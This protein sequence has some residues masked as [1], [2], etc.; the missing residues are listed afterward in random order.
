MET[1]EAVHREG[2]ERLH[3][4]LTN[5]NWLVLR[6][7]REIFREW[8]AGIERKGLRVLDL[9]GRIQPYRP[10]LS[11]RIERYLAVDLRQSPLVDIVAR[12]EEIPIG[13]D[14]VDL[15]ICA[16]VLEYIQD[17]AA[18]LAEIHRVLKPG[19]ML[20]LSAPAVYPCDSEHDLW[21]FLP[22]SLRWLLRGFHDVEIVA[23]GSS[24]AGLFRSANV[25]LV[26]F[27][28]PA[29]VRELLHFALVPVLNV[30]AAT[31]E[32]LVASSNDQFAANFSVSAR[33]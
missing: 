30:T 3:P 4:S 17:P 7:R 24:I 21:R 19:G 6:R 25:C 11:G 32:S 5:P 26:M 8:I 1:L 23:E 18:L 20:L 33:K 15:V 9:G 12:G 10:L 27:A 31:L 28:K 29:L 16:Q 14:Q 22:G 13:S 2:E